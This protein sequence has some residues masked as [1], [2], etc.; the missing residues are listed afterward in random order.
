VGLL[1]KTMDP[2]TNNME[3]NKSGHHDSVD[4]PCGN[5]PLP[6]LIE[7]GHARLEVGNDLWK[8]IA[9]SSVSVL[10]T[11]IGAIVVFYTSNLKEIETRLNQT[12]TPKNMEEFIK[13]YSPYAID[14]G[15]V[16]QS[17]SELKAGQ[18]QM[19]LEIKELK[20]AFIRHES[21]NK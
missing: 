21:K 8:W 10:V 5:C 18:T 13:N 11:L 6:I 20:E 9:V 15:S 16:T 7:K 12:V 17:L 19:S 1:V 4:V 14:R 2:E 3:E